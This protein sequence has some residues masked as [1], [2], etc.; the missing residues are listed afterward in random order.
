[1]MGPAETCGKTRFRRTRKSALVSNL[2]LA[3]SLFIG[4]K[5]KGEAFLMVSLRMELTPCEA[6]NLSRKPRLEIKEISQ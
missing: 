1:M 3:S 4:L 6:S 5:D 2:D